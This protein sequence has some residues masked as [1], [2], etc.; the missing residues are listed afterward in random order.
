MI[1]FQADPSIGDRDGVTPLHTAARSERMDIYSIL[2]KQLEAI[3]GE[4][5][6]KVMIKKELV[7]TMEETPD[8]IVKEQEIK[9][10]GRDYLSAERERQLKQFIFTFWCGWLKAL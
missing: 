10:M 9:R 6:A 2:V 3:Y 4:K 7:D 5:Q 1:L 8:L